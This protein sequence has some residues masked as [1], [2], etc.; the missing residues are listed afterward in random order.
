[1]SDPIHVCFERDLPE[2]LIEKA[3]LLA[4]EENPDGLQLPP[5]PDSPGRERGAMAP[6]K[7]WQVG[8]TLKVS[9]LDGHPKLKAKVEEFAHIWS[10]HANIKFDFCNHEK[11]DIRISFE[12]VGNWS[13]LGTDALAIPDDEPTMNFS[14]LK[15]NSSDKTFSRYVLHEFGHALGLIHEHQNPAG[16]IPWD[17]EAVL[18]DYSG[19]PNRWSEQKIRQNILNRRF[20][21]NHTEFDDKSIMLYPIPQKHTHGDFE[22]PIRNTAL[23]DLDKAFIARMYPK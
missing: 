6:F 18:R 9:F 1:M 17:E 11:A 5:D 2:E 10:D 15:L 14:S 22:R 16:G 8:R 23:S 13:M 20:S 7:R 12:G 21:F 4:H 19:P 3:R